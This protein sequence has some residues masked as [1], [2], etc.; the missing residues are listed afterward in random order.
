MHSIP[1][2]PGEA[3]AV[4]IERVILDKLKEPGK[5]QQ[6]GL[7]EYIKS[8]EIEQLWKVRRIDHYAKDFGIVGHTSDG[9]ELS[10]LDLDLLP[11]DI[12][13]NKGMEKMV[14]YLKCQDF[15][16]IESFLPRKGDEKAI[17]KFC[18]DVKNG[19]YDECLIQ[20]TQNYQPIFSKED[21]ISTLQA[22]RNNSA[23]KKEVTQINTEK[24]QDESNKHNSNPQ[25]SSNNRFVEDVKENI[26][27]NATISGINHEIQHIKSKAI[28][29][30]EEEKDIGDDV[31]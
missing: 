24:S 17:T 21:I 15:Y 22:L 31:I 25:T 29:K 7:S 13:K 19:N 9:K 3:F 23:G 26:S 8:E 20:N 27:K 5:L 6:Y 12:M 28:D 10:D 30:A 4:S 11:Y 1:Y 18:D 14:Q 2:D 16:K